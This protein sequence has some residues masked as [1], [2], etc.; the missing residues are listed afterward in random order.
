MGKTDELEKALREAEEKY[1]HIFEN[2]TEGIFQASTNGRITSA[3]P[4]LSRLH[5]YASP[6][7]LM[8]SVESIRERLFKDADRHKELIRLLM[9]CDAVSNFEVC[10]LRKDGSEHWVSLN[11]RAFRNDTGRISFYEGTM[12][13]ITTRKEGER[14]LAESEERYR[15]VIE[16]SNDGIA[17]ARGGKIEYVNPQYVAIF[18]YDS[19]DELVGHPIALHVHP[20]DRN[21][22][23]EIHNRRRL[24]LPIP[25]RYEYRGITKAGN[26]IYIEVSAAWVTN[27]KE[28][29]FVLFLRDVSERKRTEEVFLQN[30]R[31]LEQLNRAKSKAISH[32]SHELK[33]PLAVTQGYVRI[34]RRRL[35]PEPALYAKADS[36]LTS[37]ERNLERLFLIQEEADEI[38]KTTQ[39]LEVRGIVGEMEQLRERIRDMY[40]IPDEVEEIWDTAKKWLNDLVS[41]QSETFRV[42]DLLQFVEQGVVKAKRHIETAD[43]HLNLDAEQLA[44]AFVLME[45]RAL[46]EIIDGLLRNAI[47]NTPDHGSII[48]RL[49]N[50]DDEIVLSVIDYGVGISEDNQK[51]I[52][53]GLFHTKEIVRYASRK[54]YEFDAGGKGLDLLRM[55]TYAGLFGFSL[56]V[57][58]ARCVHLP[59]DGDVCPGDIARCQFCKAPDDCRASGGSTFTVVFEKS[60]EKSIASA[61]QES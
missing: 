15:T 38:L 1:R 14:A 11:V 5:G 56:S 2:A 57:R 52:F 22:V 17:L 59:D 13:D 33:T 12:V 7:E 61:G 6:Q 29:T 46:H 47:E 36:M 16:N 19:P 35:E 42:L 51:Y 60:N 53:D 24:G 34:L 37:M 3:N 58:S 55:K 8:D 49:E 30:H 18:G 9:E 27:R 23:I 32:I 20:D 41:H 50:T 43:R 40:D 44:R 54:P 21:R 48:V 31:Q 25:P 26:I 10:M 4:A 39:E 45:P 28:P